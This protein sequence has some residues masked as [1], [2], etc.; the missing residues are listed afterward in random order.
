[1]SETTSRRPGRRYWLIALLSL[2]WN[3]F[4]A[5]DF[6]MTATRDVTW[7]AN[8]PPGLIDWLDSEPS[9]TIGPWFIGVWA[10]LAGSL[11]L[12]TRSR[13]AAPAFVVSILGLSVTHGWDIASAMPGLTDVVNIITMVVVW[14]VAVALLWYAVRKT[15]QGVLR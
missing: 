15:K 12:L 5:L 13:W 3:G 14:A 11:L 4:G 1:M 2:A 10:A 6:T 7:L 9:W 8:V